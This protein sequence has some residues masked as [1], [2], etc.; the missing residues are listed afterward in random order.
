[1]NRVCTRRQIWAGVLVLLLVGYMAYGHSIG[2]MVREATFS[3]LTSGQYAEGNP[4]A[5]LISDE[6]YNEIVIIPPGY[7]DGQDI[8]TVLRC[9]SA[10]VVH[11]LTGAKVWLKYESDYQ[12]DALPVLLQFDLVRQDG[13][14]R[15]TGLDR[16]YP[17]DDVLWPY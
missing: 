5:A 12:V 2:R 8:N 14:W 4:Y 13:K 10:F 9:G 15:V 6:Y 3:A 7:A 1:M 17:M 16:E 11:W